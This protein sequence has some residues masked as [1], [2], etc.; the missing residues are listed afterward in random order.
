MLK[1]ELILQLKKQIGADADDAYNLARQK[2]Q[3]ELMLLI[4]KMKEN[5]A[6]PMQSFKNFSF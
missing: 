2:K 6:K 1:D 5:L 3:L 4:C